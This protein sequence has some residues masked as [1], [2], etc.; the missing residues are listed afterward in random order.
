M[1]SAAKAEIGTTFINGQEAVP[2]RTTL[3]KLCHPQPATTL[4][5]NNSTEEGFVNDSIKQKRPKA[6]DM[7]F[8]GIKYREI[9]GQLLVY[10]KPGST[11]LGD[12]HTK[13]HPPSHHLLMLSTYLHPNTTISNHVISHILRGCVKSTVPA[14]LSQSYLHPQNRIQYCGQHSYVI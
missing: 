13:H 8:Y 6:I 7:C 9:Q 2:I 1:A 12:Y 11:N 5:V 14:R 4:C 3:R 10:W